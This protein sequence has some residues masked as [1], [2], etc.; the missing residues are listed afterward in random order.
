MDHYDNLIKGYKEFRKE[1]TDKSFHQYR[2]W[3]VKTQNP[4]VMLISCSDSRVNPAIIT[5]AGL[6]SLFMVKNVANIVP[7]NKKGDNTHHST[8]A[9]IEF[10]VNILKVEHIIIMGHSGC[11]G[12]KSLFD[13]QEEKPNNKNND[14]FII[15]W[16]NIVAKA[17][18]IAVKENKNKTIDDQISACERYSTLISLNNLKSF[19]FV[20]DRINDKKLRIHA[21]Y[22][23]LADATLFEYIEK[24]SLF[25]ELL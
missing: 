9:A 23:N 11:G 15:P 13:K 12:I 7:P 14:S 3:A 8:S 4:K 20:Q 19:S 16:M 22:F 17:K 18:K 2:E 10:A 25:K 1:Y 6:G 24:D 5:H 21:W